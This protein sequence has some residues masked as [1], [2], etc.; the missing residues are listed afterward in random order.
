MN[1][2]ARLSQTF[3]ALAIGLVLSAMPLFAADAQAQK[4]PNIVML[5]TDD[6]GW[7]DFG[8]YSGGGAGL[9]IRHRTS[10]R[11]PRRERSS[12]TGTAR[13]VAPPAARRS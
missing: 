5:M 7:S 4:R 8:A 11:S 9:G 3:G 13:R 2:S 10:I 6:T 12:P 1:T